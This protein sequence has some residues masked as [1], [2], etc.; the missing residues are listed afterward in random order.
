MRNAHNTRLVQW[1]PVW[2]GG[3][4]ML[5]NFDLFHDDESDETLTGFITA[6]LIAI[7]TVIILK[8]FLDGMAD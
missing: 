1:G 4:K 6:V 5:F 8:L 3:P 2:Q 7:G